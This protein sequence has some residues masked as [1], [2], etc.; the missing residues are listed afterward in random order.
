M[1]WLQYNPSR[2]QNQ[3]FLGSPGPELV[4]RQAES[5]SLGEF[6]VLDVCGVGRG[7]NNTAAGHGAFGSE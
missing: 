1:L 6:G 3:Q 4:Q 2:F 7:V 5:R